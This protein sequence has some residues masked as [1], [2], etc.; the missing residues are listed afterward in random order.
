MALPMRLHSSFLSLP[1]AGLDASP[2]KAIPSASIAEL[3]VFAVYIPPHAPAPGMALLIMPLKSSSDKFPD[4][5]CPS[6]SKAETTSSF[7]SL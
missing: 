4:V 1:T 6:A 3:I 2:G 5:F 7:C